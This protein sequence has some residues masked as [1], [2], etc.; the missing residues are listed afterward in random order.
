MQKYKII[1]RD[2][3]LA[4]IFLKNGQ[5]VIGDFGFAKM[6]V[7]MTKTK[8]GTP[9]YMSPEILNVANHK[10]YSSKIDIWSIGIC[11]Y[12]L[13]FG[14]MPFKEATNKNHL[15]NLEKKFSGSRLRLPY[16]INKENENLLRKMIEFYPDKRISFEKLFKYPTINISNG[17]PNL[18]NPVNFNTIDE[19]EAKN[20]T[21]YYSISSNLSAIKDFNLSHSE[22]NLSKKEKPL[23]TC[24][25]LYNY[26]KN[27]IVFLIDTVKKIRSLSSMRF[28]QSIQ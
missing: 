1:H 19:N 10:S 22:G 6:G 23:P 17:S 26:R 12:F 28:Y 14:K 4:N 2:L 8:L 7:S 21:R 27:I 18:D 3:K 15:L 20:L 11:Y 9:Y 24:M 25:K 5:V 16:H 13:I